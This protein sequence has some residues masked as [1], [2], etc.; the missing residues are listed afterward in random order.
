MSSKCR[1]WWPQHLSTSSSSP[2]SSSSSSSSSM[3]NSNLALF[4]WLFSRSSTSLDIVVA[5]A[6]HEEFLAFNFDVSS[7][8]VA[9]NH[10]R[11][12]MPVRLQDKSNLTLLGRCVV[13]SE[14][15]CA[16]CNLEMANGNHRQ[17][18]EPPETS[19]HKS[20]SSAKSINWSHGCNQDNGLLQ[21]YKHAY[22]HNS[23]WIQLVQGGHSNLSKAI[24]SVPTLHH[25]HWNGR[26]LS[27]V[28]LHV[29]VYETPKYCSHHFSTGSYGP[30]CTT[31]FSKRPK[32]IDELSEKHHSV[33]LDTVIV[34]INSSA[35]AKV[36]FGRY[37]HDQKSYTKRSLLRMLLNVILRLFATAVATFSTFLYIVLWP[38]HQLAGYGNKSRLCDAVANI[39]SNTL[40]NFQLRRH[41]IHYWPI[42]LN[43]SAVRSQACV[44]FAEKA[45]LRRHS[46][47]TSA[48]VDVLL[49]NLLGY[50]L[51]FHKD[52]VCSLVLNFA[53]H[54]TDDVLRTGCVW[55]MGVPAGFKLNTELAGVLGGLS[56]NAIHIWSTLWFLAAHMFYIAVKVVAL[57]GILYGATISAALVMDMIAIAAFHVHV[58]HQFVGFFYSLQIEALTSL[59]RLFRGRKWNPLRQRLDSYEYSVEQHVV[60]SLMFT[61]LLLLLPTTSVFY[62]F[63]AIMSVTIILLRTLVQIIISVIHDTPYAEI[64]LWLV[65][66]KRFPS[67]IWFEIMDSQRESGS[68]LVATPLRDTC[69]S[70]Q[71]MLQDQNINAMNYVL[72]PLILRSNIMTFGQVVIPHYK[73]LFSRARGPRFAS[74]VS[75]ILT[76]KSITTRE[77]EAPRKMPWI[78]SSFKDYWCL[79]YHAVIASMQ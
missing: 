48:M 43:N 17:P 62:I 36:G 52:A 34:A 56:L 40:I 71:R 31:L 5:F 53:T 37:F 41:Q 13:P 63:F 55:L 35:A 8:Q 11:E 46:L 79:C 54:V 78:S 75:G 7:L 67:G 73:N 44:E 38:S 18:C 45:S 24:S 12:A 25:L 39:F 66:P 51:L 70:G 4:G 49:G 65:R 27:S 6:H 26:L 50:A 29:M 76:G 22:S 77:S 42:F 3:S 1:V 57:L 47:W 60:G 28:E 19:Y 9:I 64:V 74:A 69:L 58:L 14:K 59:W 68:L 2:F 33:D 32:W 61:P 16:I 10:A 21:Q 23:T 15:V 72:L 30:K 20:N